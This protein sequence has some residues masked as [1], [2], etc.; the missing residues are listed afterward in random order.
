MEMR[1]SLVE[2]YFHADLDSCPTLAHR[3]DFSHSEPSLEVSLGAVS[4]SLP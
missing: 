3:S 2:E 4:M 1:T